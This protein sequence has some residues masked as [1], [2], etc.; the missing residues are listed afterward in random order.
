MSVDIDAIKARYTAATEGPWIVHE[1]DDSMC[2]SMVL[3]GPKSV[4][5]PSD[6]TDLGEMITATLLQVPGMV[7]RKRDDWDANAEFIAA[8]RTDLPACVAEIERL[9]DLNR[10]ALGIISDAIMHGMP[11]TPEVA[12]VRNAIVCGDEN[13]SGKAADEC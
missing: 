1:C 10:R 8:A 12:A 5:E 6:E 7:G 4:P 13:P 9:R 11:I 3:V 2:M